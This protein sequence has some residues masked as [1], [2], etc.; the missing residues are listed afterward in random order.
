MRERPILFS[1]PM[2]RALLAGRKT[3]TRR[4]FNPAMT[5]KDA[6]PYGVS[7][8]RLWVREKF[9]PHLYDEGIWYWADG[10]VADADS[11][12]PSPSI[13]MPRQASRLTLEVVGTRS[14]QLHALTEEDARAEGIVVGEIPADDYGPRRI[15]FVFGEDDGRCVLY[16]TARRA[17]EVGWDTINGD[18]APWSSNPR[19]WVVE[20]KVVGR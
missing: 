19:V 16:P 17:F 15:G 11:H 13:F 4:V 1:G 8:D 20:F 9:S 3:Q 5:N 14:E 2:V 18:R 7:G 6:C 10:N 12:R